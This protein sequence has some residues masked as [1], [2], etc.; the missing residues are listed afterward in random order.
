MENSENAFHCEHSSQRPQKE[1]WYKLVNWSNSLKLKFA[2]GLLLFTMRWFLLFSETT[3]SL[4]IFFQDYSVRHN[5]QEISAKLRECL[6]KRQETHSTVGIIIN[7]SSANRR[8]YFSVDLSCI[9]R[10]STSM[11]RLCDIEYRRHHLSASF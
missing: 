11:E 9:Q 7:L 6:K 2:V 1:S 3:K 10:L 8:I 5:F 4:I